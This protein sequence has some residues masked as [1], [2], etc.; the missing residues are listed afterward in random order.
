MVAHV[1]L[2]QVLQPLLLGHEK[3]L[4]RVN[5]LLLSECHFLQLL[6]RQVGLKKWIKNISIMGDAV[7]VTLLVEQSLP[8]PEIHGLNPIIGNFYLQSTILKSR[9]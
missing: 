5:L 1:L 7:I 4:L 2:P 6:Q 8:T 3:L 9:K